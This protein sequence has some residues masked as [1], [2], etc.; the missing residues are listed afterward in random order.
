MAELVFGA[1][2]EPAAA[3]PAPT[4][5]AAEQ[6]QQEQLMNLD[7]TPFTEEEKKQILDFSKQIDIRNTQG[8]I[9]YGSGVQKKMAD[10][11][12]SVLQNV[13][14]KDLGEVGGMLSDVMLDLKSFNPDEEEKK[15]GFLGLFRKQSRKI[16]EL[17]AGYDRASVNVD[18][19]SSALQQQEIKLLKDVDMLDK[20][21]ASNLEYYKQLTMYIAAGKQKISDVKLNDLP[22]AK[23]KAQASGLAEDAQA[24]KDLEDQLT[25]F[26][27]KIYDLELTRAV[28]L[29]T[30]PQIRMIQNNDTM[31]VEKIQSTIVNTIPLWK[32][33]M[34]LA[35]GLNDSLVAA[36]AENEVNNMTNQLLRQ[37]AAKLK[38]TTIETAKASERGVVDIETLKETN[39]SLISTLDEVAKIQSEGR[40]KRA[41]AENELQQMEN[42]LKEKLL[43]MQSGALDKPSYQQ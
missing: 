39:Q 14:T 13:R 35:L 5:V 25:R 18:K 9:G 32:N 43:S 40:Q 7:G 1:E 2:P 24:A 38:Q 4:P 16:E 22:A 29:Q 8:V 20:M 21:Y 17:K 27:K 42:Q 41:E 10:F 26:E 3:Q 34:V 23:A 31:M 6:P 30:A 11:S 12:E 15:G 28:A 36:H 19:V 33:Q 37:N